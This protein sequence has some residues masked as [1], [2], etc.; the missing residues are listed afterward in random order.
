MFLIKWLQSDAESMNR[1][2]GQIIQSS[3]RP[4][5]VNCVW[6]NCCCSLWRTA[7]PLFLATR[8]NKT[9]SC[10]LLI[11]KRHF[12]KLFYNGSFFSLFKKYWW[13]IIIITLLHCSSL[14][15]MT[16]N[17]PKTQGMGRSKS[18]LEGWAELNKAPVR[19]SL[20]RKSE[21]NSWTCV[22]ICF[23]I[24]SSNKKCTT[25]KLTKEKNQTETL[26]NVLTSFYTPL[27]SDWDEEVMSRF[28]EQTRP[29]LCLKWLLLF[30]APGP[31]AAHE[32]D[33]PLHFSM[34]ACMCSVSSGPSAAARVGDR[35][36]IAAA[37]RFSCA[38]QAEW[39]HTKLSRWW[40]LRH[41]NLSVPTLNINL[42]KKQC[43]WFGSFR[44][45]YS[46]AAESSSLV[47]ASLTRAGV[48]LHVS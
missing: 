5:F 35:Q 11:Y 37:R 45:F 7:F 13:F 25:Q 46:A 47:P 9:C 31:A 23:R 38:E 48:S 15:T 16:G 27:M 18:C 44:S 24:S 39:K 4:L 6:L 2:C 34:H 17:Y 10:K 32:P 1:T 22:K 26:L 3:D 19:R 42:P 41:T 21:K 8:W 20:V 28:R 36:N 43:L 30:L 33:V 12:F 40:S 29:F 14:T